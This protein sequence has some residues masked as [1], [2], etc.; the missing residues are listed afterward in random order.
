MSLNYLIAGLGAHGRMIWCEE[1]KP[2]LETLGK[3]KCVGVVDVA[4]AAFEYAQSTMGLEASQ[5]FTSV[6]EAAA[7]SG[8]DFLI[9][10][11]RLQLREAITGAA[12]DAGLHVLMEKPVGG[13]LE[14]CCKL[15]HQA[16][17]Q[18]LKAA[19]NFTNRFFKDKQTFDHELHQ[20]DMG[21]LDYLFTRFGWRV[22][23][24][25]QIDSHGQLLEGSVHALSY[26][27]SLSRS[28]AKYVWTHA[29]NPSWSIMH[30]GGA[31]NVFIEMENGVRCQME[32]SWAIRA[33]RNGWGNEYLRADCE[34]ALLELDRQ[35]LS[36]WSQDSSWDATQHPLPLLDGEDW[37]H[38]LIIDQFIDWVD[39][40]QDSHP[41][42]FDDALQCMALLFAAVDSANRDGEKIDVQA[43][44]AQA[45]ENTA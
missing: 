41:T 2:R 9:D 4:P 13:D 10:A 31:T 21:Q 1:Q 42:R 30:D 40:K 28:Q 25:A 7:K 8:A 19:V 37:G 27:R 16:N 45:L 20:G 5:C 29:W 44:L 12:F 23:E 3:A 18:G 26:L 39:G 15:Y 17:K 43:K 33:N 22:D 34:N 35:E 36:R 14:T 6:A 24:R 38:S 11:T 32:S